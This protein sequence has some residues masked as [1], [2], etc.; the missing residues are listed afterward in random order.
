MNEEKKN[1]I[2]VRSSSD[3]EVWLYDLVEKA[4]VLFVGKMSHFISTTIC[5]ENTSFANCRLHYLQEF[6]CLTTSFVCLNM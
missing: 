3:R 2:V 6:V 1:D 4:T 5:R